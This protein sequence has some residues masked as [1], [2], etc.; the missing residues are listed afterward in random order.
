M[1]EK[2]EINIG[3]LIDNI[4]IINTNADETAE[5]IK[6]KIEEALLNVL[7]AAEQ[8]KTQG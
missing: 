5:M 7:H 8:A 6:Q 3:R 2:I 1:S 4:V